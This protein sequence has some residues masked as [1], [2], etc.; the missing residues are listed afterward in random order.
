LPSGIAGKF[1][2]PAE[3]GCSCRFCLGDSRARTLGPDRN[4]RIERGAKMQNVELKLSNA[5]VRAYAHKNQYA[6][7]MFHGAAD[8]YVSS[9]CLIQNI[10][11]T[12]FI[13]YSYSVEKLLKAIIFLETGKE[14]TLKGQNRHNS[15]LLKQELHKSK[16]YGLDKYDNFLKMLFGHFQCRYFDNKYPGKMLGTEDLDEADALWMHLFESIPFPPEVKYRLVIPSLFFE[17]IA[18]KY[19]PEYRFW[20]THNNRILSSKL[21]KMEEIYWEVEHHLYRPHR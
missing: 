3:R 11:F 19:R 21:E 2:V 6:T 13:L 12:G 4:Y 5:D 7:M 9:R 14:T 17:K 10:L 1:I 20:A 8:D 15:Y 18:L 16:D